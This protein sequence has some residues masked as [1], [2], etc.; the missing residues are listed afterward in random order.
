MQKFSLPYILL[1]LLL[2]IFKVRGDWNVSLPP[3]EGALSNEVM[4]SFV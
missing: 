2:L 1:F 3:I 4:E